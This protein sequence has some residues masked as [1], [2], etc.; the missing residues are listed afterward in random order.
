MGEQWQKTDWIPSLE[1][2]LVS[3]W[4]ARLK[5]LNVSSAAI[6]DGRENLPPPGSN[7]LSA[8][9]LEIVGVFTDGR[10]LLNDFLREK[11]TDSCERIRAACPQP[12]NGEAWRS[13][14][15]QIA[16]ATIAEFKQDVERE[17]IASDEAR[18]DLNAFRATHQL[19]RGVQVPSIPK[20]ILGAGILV[21]C[22][23]L[24]SSLNMAFF[25]H[26]VGL[27]QGALYAIAVSATNIGM[28]VMC[29]VIG[30]RLAVN[31]L[32]VPKTIGW[33]V[34]LLFLSGAFFANL[35]YAHAREVSLTSEAG[36]FDANAALSHMQNAPFA[37]GNSVL[38]FF[39]GLIVFVIGL[40]DGRAS[41]TDP[42]WDYGKYG[43][44]EATARR[45]F[46]EAVAELNQLIEAR[47]AEYDRLL[48]ETGDRARH[49]ASS[50]AN[51]LEQARARRDEIGDNCA[52]LASLCRQ[53]LKVYR[54]QNGVV[55]TADA[56]IYFRNEETPSLPIEVPSIEPLLDLQLEADERVA[57]IEAAVQRVR[58][59]FASFK[60]TRL[61]EQVENAVESARNKARVQLN[62]EAA[63]RARM[64][65]ALT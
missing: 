59:E 17:A 13:E 9:E 44:L 54:E 25:A 41:F 24:E 29:G 10:D 40:L 36:G 34:L 57:S 21:F 1:R 5:A 22:V 53:S 7:Q 46:E 35:L 58:T 62:E 20:V 33:L 6:A 37:I 31:R 63:E 49:A 15:E 51:A 8:K 26:G 39:L 56:P 14:S 2:G 65:Q 18:R 42:Y 32:I 30:V 64:K 55:R 47:L 48:V 4:Q 52:R 38:L 45:R 3:R 12:F 16:T 50:A 23:A 28:G 60:A 19:Q 27:L 61:Q 43:R 11:L